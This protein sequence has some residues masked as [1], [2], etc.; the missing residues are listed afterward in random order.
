MQNPT[1]L[2]YTSFHLKTS[3]EYKKQILQIVC[4]IL[5]GLINKEFKKNCSEF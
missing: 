3:D 4:L 2:T 5:H 1:S